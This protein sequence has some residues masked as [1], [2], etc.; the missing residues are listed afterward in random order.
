MKTS[1]TKP[2]LS[3][4]EQLELLQ[5]RGL[6]VTDTKTALSC[7]QRIGYYRLSAYWYPFR[8]STATAL[9]GRT[10]VQILDSFRD[11]ALFSNAVDLYVFDKKLRL[12]LLDALERIEINMRADIAHYLGAK[13]IHAHMKPHLLHGKFTQQVTDSGE[14]KYSKWQARLQK[15]IRESNEEFV[16]HFNRK[17]SGD[18]PLW[19]AVELWDF[20]LLSTFFQG[21]K[22]VDKAAIAAKY[23]IPRWELLESWL[24]GMNYIRN[25]CAHHSRTWNR[26]LTRQPKFP[27]KNEIPLLDHITLHPYAESRLYGVVAIMQYLLRIINP[28]SSWGNRLQAHCQSFPILDGGITIANAG[29]PENWKKLSLWN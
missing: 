17:Y 26:P 13:D 4:D 15:L 10:T 25:V 2:H 14:T 8:Q 24:H 3:Y 12:L 22:V 11:G 9:N 21:M 23:N 19:I 16:Q 29:F 18:L 20:G 6:K 28:T 7:L 27:K 5:G 1:Y